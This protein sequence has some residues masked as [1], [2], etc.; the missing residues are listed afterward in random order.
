MCNYRVW[1]IFSFL[2]IR[3]R[4]IEYQWYITV[5]LYIDPSLLYGLYSGDAF[6]LQLR[7]KTILS[8]Y[9]R[10]TVEFLTLTPSLGVI[11]CEYR[12]KWYIAKTRFFELHFCCKIYRC[13]FNHFYAMHPEAT[14]YG[15][16][17]QNESHYAVQGHS[18]SPILVP[19]KSSY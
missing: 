8:Q 18:R 14:E 2:L 1:P 12:H 3:Y 11:P 13:I 17:T 9:D 5:I 7:S 16:I 15:E 19:I 4:Y 10:A 6:Y